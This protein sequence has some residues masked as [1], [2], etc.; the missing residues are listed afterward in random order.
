MDIDQAN[1]VLGAMAGLA[2]A[3]VIG[4]C[5]QAMLEIYREER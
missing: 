4:L 3:V 2:L 5:V 1:A